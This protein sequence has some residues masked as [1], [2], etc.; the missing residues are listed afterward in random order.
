MINVVPAIQSDALVIHTLAQE[1]WKSTYKDI[2]SEE[3]I[4]F[5]LYDMYAVESILEQMENNHHFLLLVDD[6]EFLGFAS[7]SETSESKVF[8]IHKLYLDPKSQGKGAGS[9]MISHITELILEMGGNTVELNVN[10]NNLAANFYLK[11][12][13]SIFKSLDIPY[14]QFVLN[15]YIMRKNLVRS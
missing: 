4:D 10:R 15:D 14:H 7:F 5:M 13:F 8:K 6:L 12:G 11:L 3:Q 2:L 1:I 9:L